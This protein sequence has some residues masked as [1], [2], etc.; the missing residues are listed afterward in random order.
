MKKSEEKIDVKV[1]FKLPASKV[2]KLDQ[3]AQQIGITRSQLV[4]NMIDTSL[5]DLAILRTTGMLSLAMK[6]VNL[7]D[8]VRNALKNKKYEIKD[9]KKII[10]DF[11]DKE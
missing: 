8:V 10:I 3:F 7:F 2:E 4:R 6:G 9:D 1:T 11:E 5:D